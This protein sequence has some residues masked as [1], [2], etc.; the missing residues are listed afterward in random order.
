MGVV[1]ISFTLLFS[2]SAV[3]AARHKAAKEMDAQSWIA[4]HFARGVVPPF[5]FA[6]DGKPSAS[7]ICKWKYSVKK[8]TAPE[9][10]AVHYVYSYAHPDNGLRVECDVTGYTDYPAVE[11][12]LHFTNGGKENS[13]R[14]SD[15]NVSDVSFRSSV[16][17]DFKVHYAYGSRALR[18]DFSPLLKRLALGDSLYLKPLGGR[19]SDNT[20]LPFYNIEL[21]DPEGSYRGVMVAV[22][23]TGTWFSKVSCDNERQVVMK[24]GNACLN[25]FLYPNESIRTSRVCLLFWN[26]GNA[27]AGNNEFRRFILAHHTRKTDGKPT[28]YPLS[29][30]LNYGDPLPCDEYTCLTSDYAVA[31]IRRHAQFK[32]VPEMFW[33]DAGWYKGASE[34]NDWYGQVGNWVVDS[35]RF[36]T[37]FRTISEE[38][39]KLGAKLMVW[40]EPERVMP[41]T[42]WA[43]QHPE[44]MLHGDGKKSAEDKNPY[45]FNMG[46]AGALKWLCRYMGDFIEQNGIDFYRQDFNIRPEIYWKN[47]DEVGREGICEI[48]YVEGLYAY[49][50][51]LL[52][53]FPHLQIDNCASGGRRIDLETTSRSAPLWRTDYHYGEPNGY[54]CHTY[55]LSLY[56]PQHGTCTMRDD[57]YTYR[58]SFS[59]IYSY[60]WKLTNKSFSLDRM[61]AAIG[62]Y[63]DLRPYYR[64]DY[65][66]LSG[67]DR[68][69]TTDSVWLAY[70]LYRP[71]DRSGYIVAYRRKDNADSTYTVRLMG[72]APDSAYTLTD[73]DS[74]RTTTQSGRELMEGFTLKL[75]NPESSM[76]V[77]IEADRGKKH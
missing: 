29:A 52:N 61:R 11:W 9:P 54:Q 38:C 46:D 3:S 23:W 45:L 5:S 74:K 66:P 33:L 4:R 42:I 16:A 32:I 71:S 64:E 39:H 43:V 62:E 21:P 15:V 24:S 25:A 28:V 27:F 57:V 20:A 2:C 72:L 48:R 76:I 17:G 41:G 12:V 8:E 75:S 69:I 58:S 19:S 77:R 30:S 60:W 47:N 26:G 7:F 40:F 10:G 13:P 55:G 73:K 49:W 56:L 14:I 67:V 36:P 44:W 53:R 63:K 31:I 50:D 22:G 35:L 1:A 68:D 51:Y 18:S 34:Y 6:C 65:Y 37:G 70:Q 59:G